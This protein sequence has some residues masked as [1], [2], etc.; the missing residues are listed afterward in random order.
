MSTV[1]Q[2][3]RASIRSAA[4]IEDLARALERI[5]RILEIDDIARDG[6]VQVLQQLARIHTDAR[7]VLS[8][9]LGRDETWRTKGHR[10]ADNGSS[11]LELGVRLENLRSDIFSLLVSRSRSHA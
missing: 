4:S 11:L 6:N 7:L 8:E 2:E 10:F 3:L 9:L 5:S 1:L